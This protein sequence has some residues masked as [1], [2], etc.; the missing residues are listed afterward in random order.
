MRIREPGVLFNITQ[1]DPRNLSPEELYEWTRG[2]WRLNRRRVE[3]IEYAF[4][5][6][7]GFV[8]EVYQVDGW[9]PAG[10]TPY[11]SRDFPEELDMGKRLEFSGEVAPAEIRRRYLD[12]SVRRVLW[13]GCS[14]PVRYT[15]NDA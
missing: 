2:V 8:V 5:V 13:R 12:R 10:A 6:Y 4:C 14:D 15:G 7:Q 11:L 9:D 1:V 3:R